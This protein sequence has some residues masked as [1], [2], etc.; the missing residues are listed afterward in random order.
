MSAKC[1]ECDIQQM[2]EHLVQSSV[3]PLVYLCMTVYIGLL[4]LSNAA[5]LH[6]ASQ[7]KALNGRYG[8]SPVI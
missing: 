2:S 5:A 1:L 7:W 6:C 8:G 4:T 3:C